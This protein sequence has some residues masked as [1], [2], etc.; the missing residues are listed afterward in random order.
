MLVSEVLR[1]VGRKAFY[2]HAP[3]RSPVRGW[4]RRVAL[5]P[6]I[7]DS[8]LPLLQPHAPAFEAV[9]QLLVSVEGPRSPARQDAGVQ[10][11]SLPTPPSEDLGEPRKLRG[12]HPGP[13]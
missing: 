10:G 13:R 5:L 3:S 11:N 8:L 6:D 9:P 12:Q 1:G 7:T 2:L 4:G